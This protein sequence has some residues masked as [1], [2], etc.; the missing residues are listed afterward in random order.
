MVVLNF[1][2]GDSKI[3]LLDNNQIIIASVFQ[4]IKYNNI[5][6]ENFLRHLVLNTYRM[7][8][9]RFKKKYGELIICNDSTN[10]WRKE[11][12]PLYK[13]NRK[14]DMNKSDT[15]WGSIFSAMDN[16]RCE[17][18]EVFP[19]KN[20]RVERT[21][22]D[23]IIATLCQ[24]YYD[25]EKIIIISNDKDFQQLQILPNVEQYSPT[26]KKFLVCENPEEFLL[27]HIIKGDSSDGI[28]NILSDDDVFMIEDKRQTPC[29]MKKISE[30]TENI[31]EW[32]EKDNWKRNK[33]LIDMNEIPQEYRE[34]IIDEFETAV[35]NSRSNLLNYFIE[36]KLKILMTNIG[37]F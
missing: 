33:K 10:Y 27:N 8:R 11:I 26:K 18:K 30:I 15:D 9:S 28:P 37:D 21:E 4:S 6:D 13:A 34:K 3:I 23:D 20:I 5:I 22:A 1:N 14:R 31:E 7:Y 25:K 36:N 2:Y 29:G 12:F 16:I 17:I 32:K 19:Y 24:E 35:D